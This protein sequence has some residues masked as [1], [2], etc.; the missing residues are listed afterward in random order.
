MS[1][2]M[3]SGNQKVQ[4]GAFFAALLLAPLFVALLGFWAVI[5]FY[6]LLFGLP[7]YLTFGTVFFCLSLH[8]GLDGKRDLAAAG[9]VAHL[10]SLPI[11]LLVEPDLLGI[12]ALFGAPMA[13]LWGL[14][15][16]ALYRG[17]RHD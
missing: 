7:T 2:Q 12:I 5:P 1:N 14:M 16:G 11:V 3:I 15:F 6:A 8:N 17:M 10:F 13:P 4:L 9:L